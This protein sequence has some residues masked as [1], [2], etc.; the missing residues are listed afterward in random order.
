MS[1][2]D[3]PPDF[4][5]LRFTTDELRPSERLDLWRDVLTRK[6]LR[7]AIDPIPER[8]FW[9]AAS[10]RVQH[11]V[12]IGMGLMGPSISHRTRGIVA[13]DNDDVALLVNLGGS[14]LI[15]QD[16]D[17]LSL[18][19]GD[20]CLIDC[21][22]AASFIRPEGGRLLCVRFPR[23]TLGAYSPKLETALGLPI[24]GG[25]E[26]L[27][28]LVT[29]VGAL[30]EAWGLT[31]PPEASLAVVRHICDLAALSIGADR[32]QAHAAEARG[33]RAARLR[34]IKAHVAANLG[35]QPLAVEDV[36]AA[37]GITARY[38]RKLFER[39]GHSFSGYVT[40]RRLARAHALLTE[41][42]AQPLPI[43]AIAYDVGFGDLSYFNRL[44]RRRYGATPSE[45]RAAALGGR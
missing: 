29:Y 33:L 13:E 37:H 14:F 8:P 18:G 35:P 25:A 10:L 45:V 7:V 27:K 15:R 39:E 3:G 11:G 38:V 28:L 20:A 6:L 26:P 31:L 32:D 9:A 21:L 1:L 23:A 41:R 4:R 17:E 5:I 40:E 43:S 42:R 22:D 2:D 16:H 44:F 12:R 30:S 34:A 19:D 36:A 24:Q